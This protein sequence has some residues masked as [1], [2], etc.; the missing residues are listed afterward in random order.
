MWPDWW[1][2]A[3]GMTGGLVLLWLVL[4]VVLWI[5]KPDDLGLRE[6]GRLL[7][8]LLRMLTQLAKDPT[9]PRGVRIRPVSYTHLTLPT[10]SR[11]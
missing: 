3:L 8:D 11:V 6:A 4:V 1:S 7:P 2:I 9:M 5:A 10:N